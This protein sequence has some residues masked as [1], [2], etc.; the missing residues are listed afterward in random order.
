M[1]GIAQIGVRLNEILNT[2]EY[3]EAVLTEKQR[4][5]IYHKLG[6]IKYIL[7]GEKRGQL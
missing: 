6:E 4:V 5:A 1:V 3:T 7:R 2:I